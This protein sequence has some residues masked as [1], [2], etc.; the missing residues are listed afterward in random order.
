MGYSMNTINRAVILVHYDRDNQVDDYVYAYIT[1]LK[2]CT[3]H[4]V[5]VSTANLK[6]SQIEKLNLQCDKVIIRDNIGYDFMSY[7]IALESFNYA[8]YDEVLICNDSVYGPLY[9]MQNLFETMQSQKC[10]FWGITDNTDMGYHIQSYFMLVK[11][12]ILQSDTFKNF[13]EQVEVLNNKDEIIKRYEIGFSQSL[14]KAGFISAVSTHFTPTKMQ[15]ISIFLSKFTAKK[16]IKKFISI[17]SGNAKIIRIGKINNAHYFWKEL[18]LSGNVPFIKIELLRDNPMH[19]NIK[20]FEK[21][22]HS[23]SDYDTKL[24][25]NHLKRMKEGL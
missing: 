9:P 24:I 13:W 23:I 4:L 21:I 2:E 8:K 25:T 6:E 5:F 7:K 10:D 19:V 20:D 1:S 14:I 15:K 18:L 11:K 16:I 17:F 3:T 22:I 12:P